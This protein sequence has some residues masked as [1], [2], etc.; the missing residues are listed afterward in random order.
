MTNYTEQL[1]RYVANFIDE[2]AN[3]GIKHV[4]ISPGSRSTPLAILSAAHKKIKKWVVIDERSAAF[5]ALGMAK[6]TGHPVALIC[7]SGTAAANYL[8]AIIEAYYGRVP[9]IALTADRPHELRDIGASQTMN[10][11]NMYANFVKYYHEMAPPKS[12]EAMLRY[13]RRRARYAVHEAKANNAGPVHLNFP[14]Q[15]PLVPQLTLENLWGQA[16][17]KKFHDMYEGEKFLHDNDVK[18]IANRLTTF[19]KGV[20]VCGPQVDETLNDAIVMLS[21]RLQIPILADPLSQLRVGSHEKKNVITNYDAIFKSATMR[22]KLRPDYIIRFGAM[23]ISKSYSFYI[24][25]HHDVLQMVVENN[26]SIREPTN[27]ASEF[28]FAHSTLFCEQLIPYIEAQATSANWLDLWL[29]KERTVSESIQQRKPDL[30]TEGSVV[31]HLL[32]TIPNKSTLFV[33]NSMPVRDLD[34]FLMPMEKELTIHANRGVS[35][36]D[37]I[38]S[39]ALGI[40]ATTNV[41]PTL[42]IGDLSFYHDLNGLLI[43]KQYELNITII[44]INNDGGGIFSF[45]PQAKEATHFETLFGTPHDL[46]FSHVV[47]MYGGS[48]VLAKT[49]S[50]LQYALKQV[51]EEN[52]LSVIEVRTDRNENVKEH[53]ELWESIEQRL[54]P[55]DKFV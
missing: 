49:A 34:T 48:Y 21:E 18:R 13:A 3:S 8:P 7:T 43:A 19:E 37:G 31:E 4:V 11:N 50:E 29:Q 53:R 10:Q 16:D 46:D 33:A 42:L 20:I 17:D 24:E 45:L 28:I 41:K 39:T 52:G 15:E 36:I 30:L 51:Y 1:T 2:L 38:T 5:F 26:E 35:G 47:Q 27:H 55:N 25:E 40:A 12:D 32:A 22:K 23:P 6:Q 44:L 9:L 14:F 54:I